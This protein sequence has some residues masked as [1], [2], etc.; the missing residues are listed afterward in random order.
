MAYPSLDIRNADELADLLRNLSSPDRLV[1]E[2]DETS[3]SHVQDGGH[4]PRADVEQASSD[5]RADW[6]VYVLS[7]GGVISKTDQEE[8]ESKMAS[9]IHAALRDIDTAVLADMG[10]WR[11]LA[12][13]P[14]RWYL[15]AR[16]PELQP[17]DYGGSAP[18]DDPLA[19]NQRRVAGAKYQL[20]LRTFLWGKAAYDPS[21]S[22]PY[23][24]A[25]KV[26]AVNGAEIDVWH[27]HIVRVQLGHLGAIP[28]H[29][30]DSICD[31]PAAAK[32]DAARHVE[33]RLTRMKHNVLLDL[34]ED[35]GRQLVDRQRDVVLGI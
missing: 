35:D 4:Y 20:I 22:D 15:D 2:L 32:R 29:F 9:R 25:T 7:K 23:E 28:H 27:S 14:F 18:P 24:R 13:Y 12:L 11:Y 6:E 33:K 10:F 16:E 5:A 1:S 31:E 21:A 19:P 8:L 34:Y 26:R 30:I 17:Q 3:R